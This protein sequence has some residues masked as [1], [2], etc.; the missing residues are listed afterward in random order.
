M[1][2]PIFTLALAT[3][4]IAGTIFTGCQ[5]SDA[6]VKSAKSDLKDSKEE[7]GVVKKNADDETRRIADGNEWKVFKKESEVK[8]RENEVRIA[9]LRDNMKTSGRTTDSPQSKRI[10]EME[11]RNKDMRTKIDTYDKNQ[12]NSNTN[13]NWESFKRE[14]NNDM[15]SLGNSLNDFTKDNKK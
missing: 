2:K 5:S 6:N 9:E 1:K 15:N 4:L 10:D 8:I 7:L 12:S 14:F 3:T 13:T 11:Q